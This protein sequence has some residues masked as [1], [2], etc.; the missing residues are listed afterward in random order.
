MEP[1]VLPQVHLIEPQVHLMEQQ[2]LPQVHLMEQNQEQNQ[3]QERKVVSDAAISDVI[4]E[5]SKLIDDIGDKG[6]VSTVLFFI[7][8]RNRNGSREYQLSLKF[9]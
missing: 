6:T 3:N 4:E 1:Q 8:D 5:V 2:V 7:C 9:F